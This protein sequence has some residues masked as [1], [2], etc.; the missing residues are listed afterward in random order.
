MANYEPILAL[1]VDECLSAP[2]SPVD[3]QDTG[4]LDAWLNDVRILLVEALSTNGYTEAY[5]SF[6]AAY[7]EDRD[8]VFFTW[9]EDGGQPYSAQGAL[10]VN[11]ELLVG[12]P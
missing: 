2:K 11:F 3:L 1:L 7:N 12:R 8:R 5:S 9:T 10:V 4:A 6:D